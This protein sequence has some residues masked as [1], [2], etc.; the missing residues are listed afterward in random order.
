MATPF[1]GL[2]AL[3]SP[4]PLST[5]AS[6][7]KTANLYQGFEYEERFRIVLSSAEV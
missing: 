4:T 2:D 6:R 5:S 1:G 3:I 7:S